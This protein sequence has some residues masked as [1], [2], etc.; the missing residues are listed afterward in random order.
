MSLTIERLSLFFNEKGK[1][2]GTWNVHPE[3][4]QLAQNTKRLQ[5][6]YSGSAGTLDGT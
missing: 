1:Y 2:Q 3:E 5:I 6:T 4:P